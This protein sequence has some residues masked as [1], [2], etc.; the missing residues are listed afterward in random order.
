MSPLEII[1]S[2]LFCLPILGGSF[3]GLFGVGG[4]SESPL[5]LESVLGHAFCGVEGDP[6]ITAS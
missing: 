2:L 4:D 3:G 6:V 1:D 5:L